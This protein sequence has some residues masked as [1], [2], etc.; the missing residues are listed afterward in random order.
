MGSREE[1]VNISKGHWYSEWA[2]YKEINLK[3]QYWDLHKIGHKTNRMLYVNYISIFKKKVGQ[4][5]WN[6]IKGDGG[7]CGPDEAVTEPQNLSGEPLQYRSIRTKV[8]VFMPF[9]FKRKHSNF[10]S[11]RTYN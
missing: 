5:F 9:T 6:V 7:V 4:L 8:P 1:K 11:P 2:Q 3:L 10:L